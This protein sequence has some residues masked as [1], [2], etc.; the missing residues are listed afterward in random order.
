MNQ[1]QLQTDTGHWVANV[2]FWVTLAFPVATRFYWPWWQSWW[3][4]NIVS[5]EL[6]VALALLGSILRIDF[7]LSVA[8]DIWFGWLTVASVALIPVIVVHRAILIWKTQRAGAVAD[9]AEKIANGEEHRQ[10]E[11][12]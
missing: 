2:A 5:L 7:G 12:D 3:G 6:T 11:P 1:I 9:I 4:K 10:P 8:K